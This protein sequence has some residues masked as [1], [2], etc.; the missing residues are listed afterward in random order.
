MVTAEILC[1]EGITGSGKTM[2]CKLL[3]NFFEINKKRFLIINEKLFE[4]FGSAIRQRHELHL[5]FDNREAIFNLALFRVITHHNNFK[6]IMAAHSL[7]YLLFD[8]SFIT[9]II[10]QSGNDMT[11]KEI[12]SYYA[13]LYII[14]P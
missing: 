8:R 14:K 12:A 9:S 3:R 2:Q 7:D 10:Y 5:P 1:L 4:P 11:M 6:P 13:G